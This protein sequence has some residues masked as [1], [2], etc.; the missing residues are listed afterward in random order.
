[1]N[2]E[3][4]IAERA[5]AAFDDLPVRDALRT[6]VQTS[7]AAIARNPSAGLPQI[8]DRSGYVGLH[9]LINNPRMHDADLFGHLGTVTAARLDPGA[10]ILAPHD[11]TECRF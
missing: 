8:F 5:A 7:V 4:S 11:T 1:M 6:R 10:V 9:R 2:S 3:L